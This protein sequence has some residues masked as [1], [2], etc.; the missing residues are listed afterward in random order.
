MLQPGPTLALD[1]Y[2]K[3]E[4]VDERRGTDPELRIKTETGKLQ[5]ALLQFDLTSIPANSV[6]TSATMSLWVKDA[7]GG[8]VTISAHAVT[9]AWNEAQVT[10]KSRDHSR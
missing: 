2:I 9:N 5:R 3:Q 8:A 6:V 10:W 1:A 4:K 7:N